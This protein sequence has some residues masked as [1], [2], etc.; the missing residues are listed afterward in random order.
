MAIY[1]G[2]KISRSDDVTGSIS[3]L[4]TESLLWDFSDVTL[5]SEDTDETDETYLP[6]LPT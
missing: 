1:L 2:H 5:A 3:P 4:L 6:D